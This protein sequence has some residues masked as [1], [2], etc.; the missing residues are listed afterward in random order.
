MPDSKAGQ[1]Q[2][3]EN[4]QLCSH[5]SVLPPA[6]LYD[7]YPGGFTPHHTVNLK[8]NSVHFNFIFVAQIIRKL[9]YLQRPDN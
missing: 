1:T 6:P 4:G 5:L 9:Y 7:L 2:G 8:S 3:L